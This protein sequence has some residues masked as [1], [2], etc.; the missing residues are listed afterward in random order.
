L[1]PEV[2][3]SIAVVRNVPTSRF[4]DSKGEFG[5]LHLDNKTGGHSFVSELSSFEVRTG[6]TRRSGVLHVSSLEARASEM[7]SKS[8]G[9]GFSIDDASSDT[10]KFSRSDVT[11]E[12]LTTAGEPVAV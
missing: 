8:A 9:E 11:G 3:I 7:L 12:S 10:I 6:S 1:T 2:R 5:H 4:K